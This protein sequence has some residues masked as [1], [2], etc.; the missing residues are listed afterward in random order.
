MVANKDK[1]SLLRTREAKYVRH[2]LARFNFI[3]FLIGVLSI[4]VLADI[5]QCDQSSYQKRFIDRWDK[6]KAA[7]WLDKRADWW[8]NLEEAQRPT[9]AQGKVSCLPC[10]TTFTYTFVREDLASGEG[11]VPRIMNN[12]DR[13][14]E[15]GINVT[16]WNTETESRIKKSRGTEAINS[17]LLLA[18]QEA[19]SGSKTPSGTLL[20]GFDRLWHWQRADGGWD[21][22]DYKIEPL[23][24]REAQ[25][26]GACLAA[27]AVGVAPGYY[28]LESATPELKQHVEKLRSWLRKSRNKKNLFGEAWLLYASTKLSGLLDPKEQKMIVE[29][30]LKNQIVEGKDKGAWILFNLNKW[31]YSD[32]LFF[33]K[34]KDLFPE[35]RNPD[36]Y[37]TALI[38]YVLMEYGLKNDHPA[39][40]SAMTW[41]MEHQKA[42][43]SWRAYSINEVRKEDDVAA[44]FMSD[45]A[46]AWSVRA[47]LKFEER[48][49]VIK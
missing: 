29:K 30:L 38:S 20:A 22:F 43:G 37:S 39:I 41:L 48:T 31:K 24:S 27:I 16:P 19:R 23:V 44:L 33:L 4:G 11:S 13:R 18:F 35:A 15:A 2:Y 8:L 21:W 45:E 14:L 25:H 28:S 10:H 47:L 49:N 7:E 17:V 9:D 36:P 34:R 40:I 32:R 6:Q 42:D 5:A 12:I 46:T 1:K 26:S 3:F